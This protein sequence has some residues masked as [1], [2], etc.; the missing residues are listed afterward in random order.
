MSNAEKVIWNKLSNR[1]VSGIR[2]IR[3]FSVD[4]Y[5]IDFYCQKLK[6]AI[7]IDGDSHFIEDEKNYEK[8]RQNFIGSI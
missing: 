8:Q 3:Q 2:F 4:K 1:Q 7:E 6:L 5:M